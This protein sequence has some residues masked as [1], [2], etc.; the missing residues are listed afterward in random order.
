MTIDL[1]PLDDTITMASQRG[2]FTGEEIEGLVEALRQN[3]LECDEITGPLIRRSHDRSA[4][5]SDYAMN[6][7]LDMRNCLTTNA[8]A[9]E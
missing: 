3:R 4:C 9:V 7:L 2:W 8:K 5:D 1:Q 6:A